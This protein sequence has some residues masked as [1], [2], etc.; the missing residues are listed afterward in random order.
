VR[1]KK[2]GPSKSSTKTTF[3]FTQQNSKSKDSRNKTKDVYNYCKELSHWAQSVRKDQL[4][5]RK[6][7]SKT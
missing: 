3:I 7:M 1:K 2:V 5:G 6:K 4:I